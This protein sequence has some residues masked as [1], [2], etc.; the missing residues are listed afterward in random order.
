MRGR[1]AHV[2][3]PRVPQVRAVYILC[4]TG[5]WLSPRP[6]PGCNRTTNDARRCHPR[7]DGQ[8]GARPGFH[9]RLNASGGRS[10]SAESAGGLQSRGRASATNSGL[11]VC[12]PPLAYR[13]LASLAAA[14]HV[15]WRPPAARDVWCAIDAELKISPSRIRPVSVGKA[16]SRYHRCHARTAR[17]CPAGAHCLLLLAQ[18]MKSLLYGGAT[19]AQRR[20]VNPLQPVDY[21]AP[22]DSSEPRRPT[23]SYTI[24]PRVMV[25]VAEDEPLGD[26]RLG[27]GSNMLRVQHPY[28]EPTQPY[29][30]QEPP[31]GTGMEREMA[32]AATGLPLGPALRPWPEDAPSHLAP[33]SPMLQPWQQQQHQQ[34]QQQQQHLQQQLQQQQQ[35]IDA[36]CAQVSLRT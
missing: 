4:Q 30:R 25:P 1:T 36:L 5:S 32:G 12:P 23:Q 29:R 21:E 24:A 6:C 11:K 35:V 8:Q 22:L 2:L 7:P 16:C 18:A 31:R 28:G 13:Q 20:Q 9:S 17:G 15:R 27:L 33:Q 26:P 14:S 19:P 34:H 3:P 10:P